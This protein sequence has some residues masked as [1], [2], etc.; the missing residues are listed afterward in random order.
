YKANRTS[1]RKAINCCA[2]SNA[3]PEIIIAEY[4][5]GAPEVH[6]A[7]EHW[8]YRDYLRDKE[9]QAHHT[10]Q[11]ICEFSKHGPGVRRLVPPKRFPD[12]EVSVQVVKVRGENPGLLLALTNHRLVI[13]Y[14]QGGRREYMDDVL[15]DVVASWEAIF[16]RDGL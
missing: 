9:C 7:K 1:M 5:S 4:G 8:D 14:R 2:H 13:T 3:L 6:G 16:E 12:R 10:V 15:A 11:D